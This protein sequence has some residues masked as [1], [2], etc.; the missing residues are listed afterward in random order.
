MEEKEAQNN[1]YELT[2]KSPIL[3]SGIEIK[4]AVSEK[5]V[6]SAYDKLMD[7]AR[8]INKGYE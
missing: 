4:T 1:E 2:V 6:V 5:Y 7:L 8:E 3:R